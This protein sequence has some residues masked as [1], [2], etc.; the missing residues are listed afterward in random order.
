MFRADDN[1]HVDNSSRANKIVVNLFKNLMRI[2]NIGVISKSTFLTSNTK[3]TFNYL[4]Q[5]FI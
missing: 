1:K 5:A 4:K 2:P 3:K